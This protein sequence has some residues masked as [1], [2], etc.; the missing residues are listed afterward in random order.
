MLRCC[1]G[2]WHE[3]T[4]LRPAHLAAEV[5]CRIDLSSHDC[6]SY[7]ASS[8]TELDFLQLMKVGL[9]V[10]W[11]SRVTNVHLAG[12]LGVQNLLFAF[13]IVYLQQLDPAETYLAPTY[14]IRATST[15]SIY[16]DLLKRI[17]VQEGQYS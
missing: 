6:Q 16:H 12:Q 13:I 10:L 8:Y 2:G 4:Q 11:D 9:I 15:M 5:V 1:R 17:T 3:K 14:V 7:A